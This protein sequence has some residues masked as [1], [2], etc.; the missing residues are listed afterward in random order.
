MDHITQT[1]QIC[2]DLS[3]L[4]EGKQLKNGRI[5]LI[6]EAMFLN[7]FDQVSGHIRKV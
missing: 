6:P 1:K 7:K 5:L 4:P 2:R 3:S